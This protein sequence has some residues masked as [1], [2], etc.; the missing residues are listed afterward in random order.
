MENS[1]RYR[2]TL[3]Q[4]F[5]TNM[6]VHDIYGGWDEV[7]PKVRKHLIECG[8]DL[9]LSGDPTFGT[10]DQF[11]GT[12]APDRQ[13][14]AITP[15]PRWICNCRA[16]TNVSYWY[17]EKDVTID[18]TKT[19]SVELGIPST[20]TLGELILAVVTFEDGL[21]LNPESGESCAS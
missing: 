21:I 3:W 10:V 18:S 5:L 13:V 16:Y 11:D 6:K 4:W 12:F 17:P 20:M 2:K 15:P 9:K 14:P 8:I 7:K 1:E 19:I